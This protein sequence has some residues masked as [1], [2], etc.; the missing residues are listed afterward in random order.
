MQY[1]INIMRSIDRQI[2]GRQKSG[3]DQTI[4]ESE[5]AERNR[6]CMGTSTKRRPER[7]IISHFS[8]PLIIFLNS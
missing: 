1:E 2:A 6:G 7:V 8:L 4:P 5:S 3:S